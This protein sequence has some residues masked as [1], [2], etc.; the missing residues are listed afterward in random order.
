MEI[1]KI[2]RCD[3]PLYYPN[4][5]KEFIFFT[6]SSNIN[7]GRVLNG[8]WGFHCLLLAQVN[9]CLIY[10]ATTVTKMLSIVEIQKENSVPLYWF[11]VL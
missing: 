7:I 10:Y 5:S 11:I 1:K 6:N 2:I 3:V 8:N 9:P 4:V